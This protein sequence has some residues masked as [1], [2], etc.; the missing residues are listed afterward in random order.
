M[1]WLIP[2]NLSFNLKARFEKN[3]QKP[4]QH[5]SIR[6]KALTPRHCVAAVYCLP[7]VAVASIACCLLFYEL[8]MLLLFY[9]SVNFRCLLVA[10]AV[11]KQM[12]T[13]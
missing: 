5:C 11:M 2:R 12:A 7:F 9:V 1:L 3:S 10:N 8:F 13:E 6:S 4:W